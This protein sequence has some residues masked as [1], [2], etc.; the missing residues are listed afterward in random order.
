[1]LSWIAERLLAVVDFVFNLVDRVL[2]SKRD[3]EG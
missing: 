3:M 2:R 1:M